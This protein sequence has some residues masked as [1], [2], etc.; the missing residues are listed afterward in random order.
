MKHIHIFG[1][2]WL[3]ALLTSPLDALACDD[4]ETLPAA[5]TPIET[6]ID[7]LN[8]TSTSSNPLFAEEVP[9]HLQCPQEW[10]GVPLGVLFAKNEEVF[11]EQFLKK[12]E[13][14]CK[15]M[16]EKWNP[17]RP[18][19]EV[20]TLVTKRHE[21]LIK[22]DYENFETVLKTEA[23]PDWL[24]QFALDFPEF[25]AVL[26]EDAPRS[27]RIL[28]IEL[29]QEK[30]DW[31]VVVLHDGRP[32]RLKAHDTYQFRFTETMDIEN[33]I[34]E[35]KSYVLGPL[36]PSETGENVIIH[37]DHVTDDMLEKLSGWDYNVN[38]YTTGTYQLGDNKANTQNT[39]ADAPVSRFGFG[40]YPE[41]PEGYTRIPSWLNEDNPV[42][43]RS[44]DFELMD[45]IWIKLW[46]QGDRKVTGGF[47]DN[48]GV[49][50]PN[51]VCVKYTVVQRADGSIERHRR[52]VTHGQVSDEARSLL[53]EGIIPPG[54]CVADHR[55]VAIYPYVYLFNENHIRQ[56][57]RDQEF[58]KQKRV[59]PR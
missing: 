16:I 5:L 38:P 46:N 19:S 58:L 55:H 24:I 31:N 28:A 33:G 32:F 29:G 10:V 6:E 44:R 14:I 34:R 17:N 57:P 18:I 51:T 59:P 23:T 26:D 43:R 30:P 13:S 41:V 40:R 52:I 50:Y 3:V 49:F 56:L 48:D 7:F 21:F 36:D 11:V 47:M 45:R 42:V 35:L 53:D 8:P 15:E 25:F 9:E 39:D 37:L 54:V 1:I 12:I 2:M 27:M 20:W 22:G 4:G